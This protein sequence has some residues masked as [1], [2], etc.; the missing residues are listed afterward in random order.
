MEQWL[1]WHSFG[2]IATPF[3]RRVDVTL[4]HGGRR[5]IE[6]EENCV[7]SIESTHFYHN[8][9]HPFIGVQDFRT[10][11]RISQAP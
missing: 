4:A 11:S 2:T 5:I 7:F 6:L 1:W 3:H 8:K 9:S 10:S